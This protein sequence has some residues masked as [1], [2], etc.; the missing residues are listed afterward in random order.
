MLPSYEERSVW[1]QLVSLCVVF[2]GYMAVSISMM[3]KG[4]LHLAPYV[5]V[6]MTAVVL[7]V[8]MMVVGHAAA[9]LFGKPEKADERD[10]QI[11]WRAESNSSWLLGAGVFAA[12]TAM[13]FG[14][15]TV[16]IA[17]VLL[18][19]L[20]ASEILKLALQIVYYRRGMDEGVSGG[21]VGGG[22]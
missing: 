2:A 1:V 19:S 12:I 10:R 18:G 21:G 20:F 16:W 22:V 4:V 5:A 7:L 14:I 9:L 6:F 3:A 17:H 15:E 13:C 11:G 8:V